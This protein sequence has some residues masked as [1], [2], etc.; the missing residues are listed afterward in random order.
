MQVT[1]CRK[2]FIGV[3]RHRMRGAADPPEIGRVA[4]GKGLPTGTAQSCPGSPCGGLI[5]PLLPVTA[6]AGGEAGTAAGAS[7]VIG[8]VAD[9][10]GTLLSKGAPTGMSQ[11]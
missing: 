8:V 6:L 3:G 10:A 1:R 4:Q 7:S 2:R 11:R 9:A 5:L